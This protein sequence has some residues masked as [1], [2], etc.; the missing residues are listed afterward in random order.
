MSRRMVNLAGGLTILFLSPADSTQQQIV[1]LDFKVSVDKPAYPRGGGPIVAID[2]AHSNFHTA[3]GQYKPFADLLTNDGYRVTSSTRKFEA[4]VLANV[5]VLVIANANSR[6]FTDPAFTEPECDVVLQWVRNGGALL[7]IA[8]HA[9]FGSSAANLATK[10]GVTMGKGW[11]FEPTVNGV[12]TQL[13]FSRENGLLGSHP[14]LRGRDATEEVKIVKSF[15]G[16]S[17]GGPGGSAILLRLSPAAR[18]AATTDDLDAEAA[19]RNPDAPVGTPGA[20]SS[21]V[22]GR[23]QGLAMT[24]EKGR[25]IVLGEAAMFSAQVVTLP[26]GDRQV[27]FKAGM[28]AAGND[29]RQFALNALHWLSR[30]LE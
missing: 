18:E 28:N 25:V 9:P 10:F 1:D 29:D 19:A 2:E 4:D 27:T 16:Q 13:V 23:A 12:T 30:L 21:S 11:A 20:R 24:V 3:G 26:Q 17:L 7:L 6:S 5:D 15:T 14:V 8:D 22:G